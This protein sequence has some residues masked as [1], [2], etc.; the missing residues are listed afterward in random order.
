M[1]E[2]GLE[3]VARQA[4]AL[5]DVGE[6]SLEEVLRIGHL[7]LPLVKARS[8]GETSQANHRSDVKWADLKVQRR[9]IRQ[10]LGTV[11]PMGGETL[12]F[13]AIS[14]QAKKSVMT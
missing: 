7:L 12:R 13:G 1:V 5:R 14:Q 8:R 10:V 11:R 4:T 9:A 2:A 6:P 3:Q